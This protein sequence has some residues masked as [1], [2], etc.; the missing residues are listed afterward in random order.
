MI[1]GVVIRKSGPT[2][3]VMAKE[4]R[5]IQKASFFKIGT[6][7]HRLYMAEHFK[8]SAMTRYPG[9]YKPRKGERGNEHPKGFKYSYTGRKLRRFGHTLPLVFSGQSRRL[10]GIRD[11]RSTSNGGRV[12]IHARTFNRKNPDSKINMR[13]EATV[14]NA[15][16]EKDLTEQFDATFTKGIQT[17]RTRSETRVN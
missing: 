7:W 12:V 13:E 15:A 10:A 9:V 17:I 8:N 1:G 3:G 4:R 6:H 11:V 2:P 16:E 14:V 5:R